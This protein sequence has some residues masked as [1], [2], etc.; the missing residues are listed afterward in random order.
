MNTLIYKNKKGATKLFQIAKVNAKNL[1]GNKKENTNEV[2]FRAR[3]INR[4]NDV[5]SFRY[6]GIVE[7]V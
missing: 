3:V 4:D 6:D 5:R 7:L 1:F 2:G